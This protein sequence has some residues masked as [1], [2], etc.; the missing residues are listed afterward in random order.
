MTPQI[1]RIP[2]GNIRL[3]F[4]PRENLLE[5][6][7]LEY[8]N[9]LQHRKALPA[10]RVRFDGD[11]YFLQDGFHRIEAAKRCRLKTLKAEI[12]SGSLKDMERE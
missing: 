4:Q 5:E 2:I 9:E 10:I 12:Y 11:N 8:V 6:T 3:D 1:R 7:V